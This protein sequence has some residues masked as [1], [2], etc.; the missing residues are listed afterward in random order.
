MRKKISLYTIAFL[1]FGLLSC[2]ND[3]NFVDVNPKPIATQSAESTQEG[4]YVQAMAELLNKAVQKPIVFQSLQEEAAKQKD[5]DYDILLAQVLEDAGNGNHLLNTLTSRSV[6][7][8]TYSTEN[9]AALIDGFK[10]NAPLLNIYLP[11]GQEIDAA[12][13]F[14]T[15]IL[16]PSF[17]DQDDHVVKAFNRQGDIIEISADEEP[18]LP[19][20]VVGINER[21]TLKQETAYTR[22]TQE[23]IFSN[24]YHSYYL[25]DCFN[26]EKVDA[27]IPQT[28]AN[29]YRNNRSASDVISRAR[30]KS[31]SAIKQVE[32]W[33][34]GAPEV[35]LTVI[36]ADYSLLDI[37][38]GPLLHNMQYN[39]GDNGWY[40]G[41]R[42]K[43]KPRDN[44]GNWYTLN[45]NGLQKKYMKYH[46]HEMDNRFKVAIN[47]WEI[48][49]S[50]GDLIGD[51]KVNYADPL[52]TTYHM[53]NMFEIDIR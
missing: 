22:S 16:D 6:T 17:S 29:S 50:G 3:E 46:F 53:G 7:M 19:Y 10:K 48:A 15:V 39:L 13:D 33:L 42:R 24:E 25:P 43:K 18:E 12:N 47:G 44:F 32:K 37:I 8:S 27:F 14:L 26:Q 41:K 9:V 52:G 36:Y 23:A 45:W 40:K 51:C 35:H 21:Y 4:Y 5:G 34:R 30:F 11:D 38:T 2:E 1:S 49:F 28:R 31:S 20:M